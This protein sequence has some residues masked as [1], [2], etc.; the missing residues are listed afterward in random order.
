MT[1]RPD[2]LAVLGPHHI[3]HDRVTGWLTWHHNYAT[4]M[5][6]NVASSITE[7]LIKRTKDKSE[8][9]SPGWFVR[10]PEGQQQK[11]PKLAD[12]TAPEVME[13]IELG[14]TTQLDPDFIVKVLAARMSSFWRSAAGKQRPTMLL[15]T[16]HENEI[17]LVKGLGGKF[18]RISM[19]SLPPMPPFFDQ[20]EPDYHVDVP[21]I[22]RFEEIHDL[23]A[24]MFPL[25]APPESR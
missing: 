4:F 24:E 8:K 17:D 12:F 21:D 7:D 25:T 15:D 22:E 9:R 6:Q 1:P 2:I 5:F 16:R 19:P 23:M 3:L 14:L 20:I 11:L 13:A 18:L 10:N